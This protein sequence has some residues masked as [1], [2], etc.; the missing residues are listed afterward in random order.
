MSRLSKTV[1]V[2]PVA[3]AVLLFA[4]PAVQGPPK[5]RTDNVKEVIHGLEI[6]DPYRWLEDQESPETR[7][8]IDAQNAYTRSLLDAIPGREA[9]KRR[10][11]ELMKVDV[12]GMP[13]ERNG[14]LFFLRKLAG[15]EQAVLYMRQGLNGKDEVLI[16]PHPWSPDHTVSLRLMDVSEDGTTLAYGVRRGGEDEVEV[17]L[18]DVDGRKDLSDRLPR[19]RYFGVAIKPDKTG[20]YYSRHRAEGSRVYYHP[21][22][23]DPAAD[24]EIFGKGYGP[25]KAV[26]AELSADARYLIIH[27]VYGSSADRSD[28]YYQDL[29]AGTPIRPI[30]KDEH[31]AF[32]GEPAGDQLLI[33]TNWQAPN[34]RIMA[35]DLNNPA[36]E[37]WREVVPEGRSVLEEFAPAGGKLIVHYLE[38]VNSRLRIYGLDEKRPR[39]IVLPTLGSVG[40]LS[41]RWNGNDVFFSFSSFHIPTT[42][43]RL[44]MT[45]GRRELWSR[46]NV[47]VKSEDF[48][49]TQVWYKSKD[50]TQAP[51]FVLH[52]KGLE[53]DGRR[54]TLLTGYGGF[55]VSVTP[56][57][58]E[59]AV[60]WVERGG[61]YAVPNLR[62]GGEFGEAW[63]RAGMLGNKQKV[64]D[65]FLAAAQWLIQSEYTA[66]SK[67]AISGRSNGGLLVGA[68]LTQ[69]PGLFRAVVC[70]YPLLDMIRYHRFSIAR[71]WVSEYGSSENPDQLKY[72]YAYS[73]YHRVKKG[74]KYPAVLFVTGDGDTRVAP[75]HA[76]KMTA[77]L[78]AATASGLP[79]LLRY[80]TKAGHSAGLPVGK[81]VEDLT[82]ELAFMLWQLGELKR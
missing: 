40:G 68:A 5:T 71:F 55:N 59:L 50:G 21:I 23:K 63:H 53:R 8:W 45:T 6:T 62:G 61:V 78:Q 79:V 51:M 17:R 14:R 7:A 75:L 9:L 60:A 65:D 33:R 15:Q 13:R 58:R 29:A 57:F 41:G 82:D 48:E 81:Q 28:I 44:D 72:I 42:L 66:P 19:G 38:N 20:F 30:V 37:R 31:A 54:P 56:G 64:F 76:R 46:Q 52:R 10:L 35:V 24:A 36:R 26:S 3:L 16:D 77:L 74:T 80:D 47:P 69:R 22:G 11:T 25:D 18:F 49:V 43:Y 39:E 4:V 2:L 27:V 12:T 32:F 34:W 67:L 70:G 73:P 1:V